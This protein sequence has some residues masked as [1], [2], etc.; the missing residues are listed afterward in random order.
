MLA[1][2]GR[3]ATHRITDLHRPPLPWWLLPSWRE[4]PQ[5]A[6]M[7]PQDVSTWCPTLDFLKYM[8]HPET[9]FHIRKI[10]EVVKK[11]EIFIRYSVSNAKVGSYHQSAT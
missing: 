9:Q 10:K 6:F 3:K 8:G 1:L 11:R 2:A 7:S 4:S 5:G